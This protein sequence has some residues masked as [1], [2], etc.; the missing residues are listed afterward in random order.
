MS[1]QLCQKGGF[2]FIRIRY[3]GRDVLESRHFG[4]PDEA[5]EFAKAWSLAQ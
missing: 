1:S 4:T 5:L 2:F 3:E